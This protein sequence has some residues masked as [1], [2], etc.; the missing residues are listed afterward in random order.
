MLLPFKQVDVFTA[1]PFKGNPVAVIFE[2]DG[3]SDAQMQTIANWTNLSE[4]T[5]V[6]TPTDSRADYRVRIFT[7]QMELRF[8]GHPTLGTAHALLERGLTPHSPGHL[9]QECGVGLVELRQDDDGSLAFKVPAAR[10][11][12]VER[13]HWPSL[14]RAL[15][16]ERVEDNPPPQIVDIGVAWL[17]C[18][19]RD[20]EACLALHPDFAALT[21]LSEQLGVGGV[22]TFGPLGPQAGAAYEVR[23]FAPADGINEDPVTGIANACLALYLQR[24]DMA[25]EH[26]YRVRQGAAMGR[27]GQIEVRYRDDGVWIGGHSVTCVD[28]T[29]RPR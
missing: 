29:L 22:A 9:W 3:L 12:E 14:A 6:V 21:R 15:G 28:G 19:L 25:P 27:T 5:F 20:G 23:C 7:P 13:E 24:T 4:T 18:C 1:T 2:A 11:R 8:A 16:A 26:G 10:W 17:L